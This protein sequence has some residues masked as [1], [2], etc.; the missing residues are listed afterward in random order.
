MNCVCTDKVV[1]MDRMVKLDV[2]KV[3]KELVKHCNMFKLTWLARHRVQR[4]L[5]KKLASFSLHEQLWKRNLLNC[6]CPDSEPCTKN[7]Q[8]YLQT[9]VHMLELQCL[10]DYG[11]IEIN[12]I[13]QNIAMLVAIFT[14]RVSMFVLKPHQFNMEHISVIRQSVNSQ[15]W[16]QE[17]INECIVDL[18]VQHADIFQLQPWIMAWRASCISDPDMKGL[19]DI[20]HRLENVR[21]LCTTNT[22]SQPSPKFI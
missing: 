13:E 8:K 4:R 22:E 5:E 21:S 15:K 19:F 18:K 11:G 20:L 17:Y 1:D 3:K 2:A 16:V 6:T 9:S 10:K 7:L 14:P 12:T